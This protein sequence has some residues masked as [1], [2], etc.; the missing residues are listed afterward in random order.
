[1]IGAPVDRHLLNQF[2]VPLDDGRFGVC[3]VIRKTTSDEVKEF[4]DES[5]LLACYAWIG[6]ELPDSQDPALRPI[7]HLTHHSWNN[8]P[9]LLWVSDP[10]PDHFIPVGTIQSTSEEKAIECLSFGTWES[11]QIQPLA[12]WRWDND[13]EAVLAEDKTENK[14]ESQQRKRA[15]GSR[16]QYLAK[17]TLEQL[18]DRQ[19]F[20]RWEEYPPKKAILAS[21]Q[22]MNKTVKQ[23]ID[24]GRTVPE[25]E[26][27]AVLQECIERFNSIDADMDHFIE[28][29]EREDICEEIEGIVHACGLGAHED[30]AD[31][32]RE[33]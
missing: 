31:E 25:S 17:L 1:M 27:M 2:A 11:V 26:R 16:D 22:I 5:V 32:W 9:E 23:L 30:V 28:T 13:R 24:L 33:W 14:R 7:L 6:D 12:Q 3:R 15:Q 20:P 19:F 10:P 18:G 21:R 4:G 29:V 8:R